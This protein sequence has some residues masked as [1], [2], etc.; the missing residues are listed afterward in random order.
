MPLCPNCKREVSAEA[1]FCYACGKKLP[2]TAATHPIDFTHADSKAAYWLSLFAIPFAGD[3]VVSLISTFNT[4]VV[5]LP[6]LSMTSLVESVVGVSVQMAALIFLVL[7]M[8]SL[9]T[10]A[11]SDFSN[12]AKMTLF[13]I[14]ALPIFT[15][16][17]TYAFSQLQ[18]L[19]PASGMESRP[20]PTEQDFFNFALFSIVFMVGGLVALVG[21]VGVILGIWRMAERYD[22]PSM[23][24]AAILAILPFTNIVAAVLFATGI[25]EIRRNIAK[26]MKDAILS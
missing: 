17:F 23:K 2:L 4:Y 5:G 26:T 13:L 18:F 10:V 6:P 1:R 20:A 25:A 3:T 11:K 9:S 15:L 7:A 22:R 14:V 24:V 19:N 21:L 16:G 8:R 12:P